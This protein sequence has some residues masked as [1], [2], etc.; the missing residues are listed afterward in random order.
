[1]GGREGHPACKNLSG[2]VLTWLS[3]WS[4]VQMI[5]IWSSWYHCHP[6]ISCCSKIQ[7]GLPFWCRITQVVLEKRLLNG[8]SSS[9][10][11]YFSRVLCFLP[12]TLCLVSGLHHWKDLSCQA[13]HMQVWILCCANIV[14]LHLPIIALVVNCHYFMVVISYCTCRSKYDV[15]SSYYSFF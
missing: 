8:C 10:L 14:F 6:I 11:L 1:L 12:C 3:V 2:E 4:E 5:C 13:S 7:N 15:P 9:T